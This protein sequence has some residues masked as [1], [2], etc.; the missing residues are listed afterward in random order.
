ME[1]HTKLLFLVI[2]RVADMLALLL[3]IAS[4]MIAARII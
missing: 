4:V 1:K 3:L 2:R